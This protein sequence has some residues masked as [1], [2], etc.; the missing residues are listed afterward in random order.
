MKVQEPGVLHRTGHIV[1]PPP[2]SPLAETPSTAPDTAHE[3]GVQCF[4]LHTQYLLLCVRVCV[5]LP[6]NKK[7]RSKEGWIS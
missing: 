4:R 5:R 2:T 3:G 6:E 1:A 7:Y